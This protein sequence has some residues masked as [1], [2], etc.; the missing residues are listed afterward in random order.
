MTF[1][2]HQKTNIKKKKDM[3]ENEK[4]KKVGGFTANTLVI[5][6]SVILAVLIVSIIFLTIKVSTSTTD[7]SILMEQSSEYQQSATML[8]AGTSILSEILSGFVQNPVIPGGPN[9]G[10]INTGPLSAYSS[11]LEENRRATQIASIFKEY[12]LGEEIQGYIDTAAQN[13]VIMQEM[14]TH[15]I[16]LIFSAYPL[17]DG[18]SY[19]NIPTISLT[20]EELA[21][22]SEERVGKAQSIIFSQDYSK[23]KYGINENIEKCHAA[24]ERQFN[25]A[26]AQCRQQIKS[27]RIALWSTIVL[28]MVVLT[29]TFWLFF[30][31]IV[32]PLR[33]YSKDMASDQSL[34]Q[35]GYIRELRSMVFV[36]NELLE[37]RNNL[38]SILRSEAETDALT[39]LPNR[40]QLEQNILD[41]EKTEGQVGVLLFDINFLKVVNDTKG[42][43]EGDKLICNT[44]KVILE[45]FGNKDANNCYRIGGDEFASILFNSTEDDIKER[46]EKFKLAQK[47]EDISVSVG[48]AVGCIDDRNSFHKLMEIAD[49]NMYKQKKSYHEN[50]ENSK[51]G[52]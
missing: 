40:Y 22:T 14:Q 38:E 20:D 2:L 31:W 33:Q 30:R 28:I 26:A 15:A 23:C 21:L 37:R 17:P 19:D 12:N 47:R 45:C 10:K 34:K 24:L 8:Q 50:V 44:A 5:P 49:Q 46:I 41:L 11:E 35:A 6:L 18:V 43:L 25:I 4:R 9:A 3:K 52:F 36:Y 16:S 48:Y 32:R 7:L 27:L 29:I 39:G 13:S 51:T 42:H 1:Q